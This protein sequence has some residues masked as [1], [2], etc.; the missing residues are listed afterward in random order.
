VKLI[1]LLATAALLALAGC[2]SDNGY[3]GGS[4]NSSGSSS[5]TGAISTAKNDKL[6]QTVLVDGNGMTIY[7]LSAEKGGKFICTDSKCLSV[8]TPLPGNTSGDVGSLAMVKRPDGKQQATY[9]GQPLYTFNGDK[10]K[11]DAGGE[12]VKDVGT[13]HAVTVSG[14]PAASSSGSGGGSSSGGGGGGYGGY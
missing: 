14:K 2:G 8:W 9:K 1:A 6:G 10:A 5:D 4:S 3:G 7:A 13:W 12:G 11:G